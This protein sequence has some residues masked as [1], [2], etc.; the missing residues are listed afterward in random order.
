MK[1]LMYKVS[2]VLLGVTTI[3]K[4]LYE[5][6]G[7]KSRFLVQSACSGQQIFKVS[8]EI[9]LGTLKGVRDS[10]H[11]SLLFILSC[12]ITASIKR[13]EHKMGEAEDNNVET[14]IGL[15]GAILPYPQPQTNRI[16]VVN[17]KVPCNGART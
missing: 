3:A 8:K 17:F 7:M 15:V 12:V 14:P 10:T 4:I 6:A 16:T 2:C 13:L 1:I 9:R 11:C 5:A